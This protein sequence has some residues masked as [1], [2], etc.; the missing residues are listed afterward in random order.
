MNNPPSPKLFLS[1]HLISL[2]CLPL[3]R[4]CGADLPFY[5][6][7]SNTGGNYTAGSPYESN[8]RRLL[9]SL[10]SAAPASDGYSAAAAGES[11]DRV[12]GIA[13]CRG[14]VNATDCRA[15]LGT[16]S[17]DIL[18]ACPHNRTAEI[19]FYTCLLKYSDRNFTSF[20]E[21]SEQLVLWNVNNATFPEYAEDA[22]I[23]NFINQ[24]VDTLLSGVA[25]AAVSSS[26]SVK[27]FATG[28]LSIT[29]GFP[30]IHG[31]AQCFPHV[32]RPEC[33]Q[34][35]QG[36][37]NE[38]LKLFDG[39]QGGQILGSWCYLRYEVYLFYYGKPTISLFSIAPVDLP[40]PPPPGPLQIPTRKKAKLQSTRPTFDTEEVIK[41]WKSEERSTGFSLFD[42]ATIAHSTNNFSVENK[43]GEGGF[44]LS[45]RPS[46]VEFKNEIQLI[47][48]LQHRNLVK[49]LDLRIIHRDLKASNILLDYEMNPKISDFG[50]ARIFGSNETQANTNRVVAHSNGYMSPEYASEGLFSVKSDVFSF[51]VLLLEIVS[52]KR[53]AGF[54]QY[55]NHLNLLDMSAWEL[56]KEGEWF[57]L[58]DQK[59][60]DRFERCEILRCIHHEPT[61]PKQ[62]AYFNV[63]IKDDAKTAS[64]FIVPDTINEVT[65]SDLEGR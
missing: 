32:S 65:F 8:L 49:L 53:N 33:R 62:P 25:D 7:C 28:E 31:L 51:G 42:F 58:I 1:L 47:A 4:G 57:E 10:S 34:C 23:Y 20:L 44:A 61:D 43:L 35:L 24:A 52:G 50:L 21:N 18:Q 12:F 63:R 17:I 22:T 39:R 5:Q 29:N 16:A 55:G 56:W 15:C 48:K 59:L 19:L 13:H 6:I 27:L 14:D 26:N 64:D 41:L 11:S 30:T 2:F 36:L 37:I 60:E 3:L 40:S 46:L 54:H 38:T 45:T 9:P